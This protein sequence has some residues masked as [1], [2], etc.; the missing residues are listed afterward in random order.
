MKNVFISGVS[1]GI[2]YATAKLLSQKHN[3]FGSTRDKQALLH[4]Q[5]NS[6]IVPENIYEIDFLK[7]NNKIEL[8]MILSPIQKEIQVL[9]NNAGVVIFTPFEKSVIEDL[10]TQIEVNL[11]G[12]FNLTQQFLPAMLVQR[13]GLIINLISIAAIKPFEN[14]SIYGASKAALATMFNSLR[15]E[16]RRQKIKITNLVLGA[17]YTEVWDEESRANLGSRM[18]QPESIAKII[19]NLIDLSENDDFMVED[20]IVRPQF[21]DL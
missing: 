5:S 3:V 7:N 19:D 18:I 6:F 12:A 4:N 14:S 10:K 21:G 16:T 20:I 1:S 13:Q 17:T 11:Y 8:D 9:I 2:G 15:E